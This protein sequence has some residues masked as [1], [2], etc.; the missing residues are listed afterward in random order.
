MRNPD[1]T[2][3]R[4]SLADLIA[5]DIRDRVHAEQGAHVVENY[6]EQKI[7]HALADEP[8]GTA[9]PSVRM[10]AARLRGMGVAVKAG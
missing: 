7:A 10:V 4:A 5:H 9:A 1:G 8:A 6:I 2:M 3:T